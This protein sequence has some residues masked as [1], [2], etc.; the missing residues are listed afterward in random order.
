MRKKLQPVNGHGGNRK[1][2]WVLRQRLRGIRCPPPHRERNEVQGR[3]PIHV[4]MR[5]RKGL[6][7]LSKPKERA[8][9][10]ESFERTRNGAGPDGFSLERFSVQ[11]NHF[12][13]IV[14]AP[15]R[16]TLTLGMQGLAVRM[17]KALNR[18]WD[19]RGKV[20]AE[21]Y[22][23]LELKSLSQVRSAL[24]GRIECTEI[25]GCRDRLVAL[26]RTKL[27]GSSVTR[28]ESA[29]SG[30]GRDPVRRSPARNRRATRS[31][32]AADRRR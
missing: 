13:L 26:E 14:R 24:R 27:S 30:R 23:A 9:V 20:F 7:S 6:R 16:E 4:T 3:Y 11:P 12:H 17:S 2:N 21:R 25:A 32:R 18:L 28:G 5:V 1:Q 29:R 22:E 15:D 8:I 10:R 19:R 31:R